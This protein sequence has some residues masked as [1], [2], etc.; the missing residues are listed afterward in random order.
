MDKQSDEIDVAVRRIFEIVDTYYIDWQADE[1]RKLIEQ[2]LETMCDQV[3]NNVGETVGSH[4][5]KAIA[6]IQ[7]TVDRLNKRLAGMKP[8]DVLAKGV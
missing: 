4:L 6:D 8:G 1:I 7:E 2:L 5:T 3:G